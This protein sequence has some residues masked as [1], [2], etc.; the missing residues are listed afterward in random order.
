MKKYPQLLA[1][2]KVENSKK[3]LYLEDSEIQKEV[4]RIKTELKGNGRVIIRPSGTEP[5]IRVMLEGPE[6][7]EL[8]KLSKK[9][10]NLIN[11][12]LN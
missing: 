3:M 1:N 12:K 8:E 4:E 9:L 10:I 6:Q 11:T 2:V 7:N 5:L